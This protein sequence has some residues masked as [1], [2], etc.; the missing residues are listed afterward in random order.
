MRKYIQ[1]AQRR[2]QVDCRFLYLSSPSGHYVTSSDD[3]CS[4]RSILVIVL[5]L[6]VVQKLLQ[7]ISFLFLVRVLG[8]LLGQRGVRQGALGG[9]GEAGLGAGAGLAAVKPGDD[10]RKQAVDIDAGENGDI[11]PS[12][13]GNVGNGVLA[14]AGTGDEVTVGETGVE[15]AVKAL[16]FADIALDAVGNLL[17]GEAEEMIGLALPVLE[18]GIG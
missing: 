17:F 14:A 7:V 15:D 8:D 3:R 4:R 10:I 2:I 13:D 11:S 18:G 5:S 12:K 9:N 16:G 6:C 1:N